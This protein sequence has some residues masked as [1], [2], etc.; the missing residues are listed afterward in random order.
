MASQSLQYVQHIKNI[1]DRVVD[2]Q[3][4]Q[5]DEASNIIVEAIKNKKCIYVFGASH[6][7]I[8][9]QEVFYRTG[10]LVPIN[11]ILPASLM[12]NVRPVT[13]TSAME[14]LEG[15][16]SEVLKTTQIGAG[17]VLLIHSVSG[18]NAVAIDMALDARQ[19]GVYVIALTNIS[20]SSQVT[21]RHSSGKRLYECADLVI[22]NCGDFEDSCMAIEHFD[23]K[24]AP[25]STVIGAMIV[26]M[27]VVQITEKLIALGIKPPIYHSANVDGG[28]AFN[29]QM[30]EKYKDQIHY[31]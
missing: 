21:A 16:G 1:M 31:L 27:M 10:G 17:D 26:N 14:R 3:Y 29:K 28:D 18:R 9:A 7:G 15:Y 6:A 4:K 20:Y 23:Q 5:I 2:T 25:S 30:F 19:K 13:H 24:V 12:L 8:I 11:P 22:D